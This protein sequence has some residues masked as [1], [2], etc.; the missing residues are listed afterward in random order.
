ADPKPSTFGLERMTIMA[1]DSSATTRVDELHA[2]NDRDKATE[3]TKQEAR[4]LIKERA[5]A[6]IDNE[7]I[8]AETRS[9]L[10]YG[11]EINDPVLEELVCMVE[12]GESLDGDWQATQLDSKDESITTHRSRNDSTKSGRVEE[13]SETRDIRR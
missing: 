10:K 12:R 6:L 7:A 8:D 9:I 11:L 4:D 5:R 1:K 13:C 2:N 3:N